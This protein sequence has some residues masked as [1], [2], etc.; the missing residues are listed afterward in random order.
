MR[1][2][3]PSIIYIKRGIADVSTD[4]DDEK[5]TEESSNTM[6]N[7]KN[8]I[9]D[10]KDKGVIDRVEN[11]L[12][13]SHQD[14]KDLESIKEEYDSFFDEDSG[15]TLR[16]GLNE[17]EDYLEEEIGSLSKNQPSGDLSKP[18]DDESK[19]RKVEDSSENKSPS[20]ADLPVEMP[21]IF[22]DVD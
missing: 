18:L 13:V 8:R 10:L 11:G 19:K 22:D 20:S 21:S 14:F 6:T 15:N 5:I 16:K 1:F 9:K 3:I 7:T 2:L 17:V 4:D 12:P